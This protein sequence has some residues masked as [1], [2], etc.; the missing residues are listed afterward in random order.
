MSDWEFLEHT[1]DVI[2]RVR[3]PSPGDLFS[4]A[5]LALGEY[6]FGQKTGAGE[7]HREVVRVTAKEREGLLVEWLS[8]MLFLMSVQRARPVAILPE[9][10]EEGCFEA[11]VEF[12]SAVP[13]EEIKA[14]TWH[15][16]AISEHGGEFTATVTCDL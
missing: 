4:R 14:V 6:I 10:V 7:S 12:A 1:G 3:A 11:T 2:L 5:A 15:G 13:E 9:R 8:R 16:L